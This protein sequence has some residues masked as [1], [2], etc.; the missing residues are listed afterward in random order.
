MKLGTSVP[1]LH[2]C[3]PLQKPAGNSSNMGKLDR[4]TKRR[5]AGC[6]S[7]IVTR[8]VGSHLLFVT[9]RAFLLVRPTPRAAGSTYVKSL[10]PPCQPD[11]VGVAHTPPRAWFLSGSRDTNTTHDPVVPFVAP[12][13]SD[14]WACGIA[15][16]AF[17]FVVEDAVGWHIY[18]STNHEIRAMAVSPRMVSHRERDRHSAERTC[19]VQST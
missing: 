14:G 6:R 4:Q 17:P 7:R 16:T 19:P 2:L 11:R 5:G 9:C 8:L 15:R 12:P 10:V 1:N 3:L 13:A 18:P